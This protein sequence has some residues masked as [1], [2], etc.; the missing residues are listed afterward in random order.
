MRRLE[1]DGIVERRVGGRGRP[2]EYHLTLAGRELQPLVEFLIVWGARWVILKPDPAR[3]DPLLLMWWMRGRIRRDHLPEGRVVV[4]F[5]FRDVRECTAWLLLEPDDVSVYI[6]HP[7]FDVDLL[8]TADLAGFYCVWLGRRGLADALR[9]G[10][11]RLDGPSSPVRAFPG[12]LAW[13]PAA[14]G[15]RATLTN[16]PTPRVL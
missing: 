11:V 12:W 15:V 1:R 6:Q 8:V 7:G 5:D 16:S 9:D 14:D 10:S 2:T 13:S 4:Q 3:M